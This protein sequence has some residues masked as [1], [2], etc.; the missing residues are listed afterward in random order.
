[1]SKYKQAEVRTHSEI[2][3]ICNKLPQ[4]EN[5][6]G[7]FLLATHFSRTPNDILH[8]LLPEDNAVF[9]TGYLILITFVLQ[10]YLQYILESSEYISVFAYPL[11]PT[12]PSLLQSWKPAIKQMLL[13]DLFLIHRNILFFFDEQEEIIQRI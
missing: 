2:Q 13:N 11:L 8:V 10:N 7:G 3:R 6:Q 9:I 5:K 4:L 1:M 12:C